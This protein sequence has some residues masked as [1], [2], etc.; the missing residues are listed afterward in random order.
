MSIELVIQAPSGRIPIKADPQTSLSQVV[1]SI[2]DSK[3]AHALRYLQTSVHS[4]QWETMTLSNLGLKEGARAKLILEMQASTAPTATAA[5]GSSTTQDVVMTDASN[6]NNK[7]DDTAAL[8]QALSTILKSNFDQESQVCLVTLMKVLDNVLQKPGN[9]KVRSIRLENPAVAEKI[10][11]KG[12]GTS[13]KHFV[14]VIVLCCCLESHSF[15]HSRHSCSR[16][17]VGMWLCAANDSSGTP[18]EK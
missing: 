13:M 14:I 16:L 3:N 1:S 5:S 18:L 7:N 12:G 10:V 9:P 6:N 8:Q 4:S 11:S 2:P 17:S 15:I